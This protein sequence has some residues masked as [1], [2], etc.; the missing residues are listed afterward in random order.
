MC[1]LTGFGT[2]LDVGPSAC[3]GAARRSRGVH[4]KFDQNVTASHAAHSL[5]CINVN[6]ADGSLVRA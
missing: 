1:R 5:S 3:V 6:I 4:G 2:A